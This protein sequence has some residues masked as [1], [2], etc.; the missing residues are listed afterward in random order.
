MKILHPECKQEDE[1]GQIIDILG[2]E[3]IEYVTLITSVRGATRG[4]HYHRA[5]TQTVYVLGGRLKLLTQRPDE[6]VVTAILE[7][8]DLAVTEPM[9]RHTMIALEDAAFMV[10]TR[11]PRGGDDYESDTYRVPPL[12]E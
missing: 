2:Q 12:G 9:E 4:S 5:T 10:F 8:G 1:R 3:V 11:G 6:P 7:K